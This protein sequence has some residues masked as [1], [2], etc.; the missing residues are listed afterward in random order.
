MMMITYDHGGGDDVD[1][2]RKFDDNDCDYVCKLIMFF[3][4][5]SVR[6]W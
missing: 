2:C 4:I 5:D 3:M 6:N 1:V